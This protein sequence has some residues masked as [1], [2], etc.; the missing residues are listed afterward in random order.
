MIMPAGIPSSSI[1]CA[2]RKEID[3]LGFA[4]KAVEE[5]L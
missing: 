2:M 1:S 5:A 4:D 3:L